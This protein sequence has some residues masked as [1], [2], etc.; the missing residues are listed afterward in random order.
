MISLRLSV[1]MLLLF[2]STTWHLQVPLRLICGSMLAFPR[3]LTSWR[4]WC[5]ILGIET[6]ANA[7]YWW[8]IDN[9]KYLM[10]YWTL[11]C[12]LYVAGDRRQ[13]RDQLQRAATLMVGLCFLF[14]IMWKLWG[15]QYLDGSFLQ[16]HLLTDSRLAHITAFM[17]NLELDQLKANQTLIS[18]LVEYPVEGATIGL[19]SSDQVRSLAIASSYWTLLLDT[20]N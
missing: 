3:L 16:Y 15:G 13:S 1:L 7:S 6:Y 2:G 14:A 10:T 12:C 11:C 19:H 20:S 8:R 9:H 4:L 5:V 17:T 18:L